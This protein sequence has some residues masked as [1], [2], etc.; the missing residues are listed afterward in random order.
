MNCDVGEVTERLENEQ[1]S[2]Q[3]N[4]PW[5]R[6]LNGEQQSG[7]EHSTDTQGRASLDV[8][9]MSGPPPETTEDR[10]HT[11]D[12][13]PIPGRKLKFLEYISK[14]KLKIPTCGLLSKRMVTCYIHESH[15]LK[16]K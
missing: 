4:C 1:S 15:G 6:C 12:I 10:T 9:T 11:K 13:Y 5:V 7:P 2:L 14:S 8:S 16:L 3:P